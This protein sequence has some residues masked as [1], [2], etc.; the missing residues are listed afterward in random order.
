MARPKALNDDKKNTVCSLIAEGVSVRQAAKF[1]GC[2][3]SS[4]RR[5]ADRNA[6]FRRQL[7]KAKSE[8]TIHPLQTLHQAAKADWRAALKLMELLEP[9]RFGRQSANVA[10]KRDVNHF[11][12]HVVEAIEKIV[13]NAWE[14]EHLFEVVLA[15]M[16]AS[17]RQCWEGHKPREN[18]A[19][20][21]DRYEGMSKSGV[22]QR[23][24]QGMELYQTV[25]KHLP[26]DLRNRLYGQMN[27]LPFKNSAPAESDDSPRRKLLAAAGKH[28]G[29]AAGEPSADDDSTEAGSD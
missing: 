4:I 2:D 1:V 12:G 29:H 21:I 8:A 9:E 14:R 5:E 11:V 13:S 3:S 15:A 20:L 19:K 17:V 24:W 6:G 25:A 26:E 7:A 10:S 27:L 23:H 18:V 28:L 22:N 16:S